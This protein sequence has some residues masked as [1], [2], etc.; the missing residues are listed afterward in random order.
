[1]VELL[2]TLVVLSIGLLGLAGFQTQMIHANSFSRDMTIANNIGTDLLEEAKKAVL[3]NPNFFPP[4]LP[5]LCNLNINTMI[6]NPTIPVP[7]G[8]INGNKI[9][10]AGDIDIN[11][12]GSPDD[13]YN[14]R[15][16]W[17]RTLKWDPT[18]PSQNQ[19]KGNFCSINVTVYWKDPQ[20][21]HQLNITTV[22]RKL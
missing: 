18:S 7:Y 16:T 2:I 12:D 10:D 9:L 8:D 3:G 5:S 17:T 21:Q 14:G 22:V 13:P 1:M 6:V 11:G 4:V 20:Q 19:C 15:F